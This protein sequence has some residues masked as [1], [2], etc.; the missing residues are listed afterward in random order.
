MNFKSDIWTQCTE[1]LLALRNRYYVLLDAAALTV[2]P[3]LALGLRL[4]RTDWASDLGLALLLYVAVSQIVKLSVFYGFGLYR[5]CWR[6]ASLGDLMQV[7]LAVGF[8]TGILSAL[9]I[10]TQAS[11]VPHGLALPQS[12]PVL[13]G[14]LTA[15]A[16]G[17]LRLSMRGLYHWC[18]RRKRAVAGRRTLIVGAGEAGT[19]VAREMG[20]ASQ[21][22]MEPFAFVD[23]DPAKVGTMVQGLPVLGDCSQIADLVKSHQVE[24]IVVAI[25]SAPLPRQQE[26]VV[27]CEATGV[28]TYSLPGIYQLLA[29]YKTVTPYPE[30]DTQQL[31]HRPPIQIDRGEMVAFLTG[32]TVLVTGAG[33]SIGSELCRQI[34]RF[35]PARIV[36]LGHGENSIFEINL[37]LRINCPDLETCPVIVDVRDEARVDSVVGEYQPDIIFHAAAHKHVHYVEQN[38][39][40]GLVNNVLGTRNV[41]R[42]AERHGVQ[43]FVLIS[44]DKAVNPS[45][46]MGATKRLAE[47]LTRAVARRTG[48]A[49]AAVR[50]GNVLG[51]RGSVIPIF[52][53]QIAAGGPVTITHPDMRRFFMTIPE[54]VQL[55]LGAAG[56]ARGGE[57]FVLDMGEQ[58]RILDL[59]HDLIGL[60]GLELGRDIEIVYSGIRPG[61]KLAEELYLEREACQPTALDRIRVVTD[62]TVYE[63]AKLDQLVL[64]V[65]KL[66]REAGGKDANDRMRALVLKISRQPELYLPVVQA[67]EKAPEIEYE[68]EFTSAQRL[69]ASPRLAI[70]GQPA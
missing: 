1:T 67:R 30:V 20:A 36:L 44:T 14:M 32:A 63:L 59:A 4:G 62:D 43:R 22:G 19:L 42:A 21:L 60:S 38:V 61:E 40:E 18:Y 52:Q 3:G 13:D 57:V 58:V 8:S 70:A 37:N 24:Q 15:M 33:G 51:S 25:P 9:V 16:V 31:L 69:A 45:C 12:L 66:A 23:D 10:G 29:G 64:D 11:L 28:A 26:L 55:V 17:G 68:A 5:R 50:F 65:I 39:V 46:V 35:R 56:M 6:Y 53:R 48:R 34:A 7:L 41:L 54:A 49:Y 27:R 47:L 2:I